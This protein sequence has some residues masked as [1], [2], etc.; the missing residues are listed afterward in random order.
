[1]SRTIG[2]TYRMVLRAL[3]DASEGKKIVITT[4]CRN[5]TQYLLNMIRPMV[6]NISDVKIYQN[7]IYF[8]TTSGFIKLMQIDN[9]NFKGRSCNNILIGHLVD[10]IFHD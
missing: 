4:S 6:Y 8:D 10:K 7:Q 9:E 2:K 3:A 1:M 5:H